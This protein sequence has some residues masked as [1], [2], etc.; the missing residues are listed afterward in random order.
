[1]KLFRVDHD[2][3]R[4]TTRRFAWFP[5]HITYDITHHVWVRLEY[6]R[7]TLNPYGHVTSRSEL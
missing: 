6:Y 7:V 2:K 4:R 3:Y 5:V 1:M